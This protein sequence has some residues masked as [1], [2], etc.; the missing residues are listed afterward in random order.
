MKSVGT[1]GNPS[2]FPEPGADVASISGSGFGGGSG[3]AFSIAAQS[4]VA[5]S[6]GSDSLLSSVVGDWEGGFDAADAV[7][8]VAREIFFISFSAPCAPSAAA[9]SA[10]SCAAS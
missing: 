5:A 8:A 3:V 4:E 10:L 7:A 1:S 2:V 9:F 6:P